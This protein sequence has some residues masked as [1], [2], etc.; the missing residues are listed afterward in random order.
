[1]NRQLFSILVGAIALTTA[2]CTITVKPNAS[3]G[4]A[5]ANPSQFSSEPV[6]I[7]SDASA[8][9]RQI[10]LRESSAEEVLDRLVE[11]CEPETEISYHSQT[12]V[13]LDGSVSAQAEGTLL[14]TLPIDPDSGYCLG[15]R[16][17][18][19]RQVTLEDRN[20]TYAI[21]QEDY[22]H[23]YTI[24]E[25]RS[26]SADSRYLISETTVGYDGGD[27]SLLIGFVDVERGEII[28]D[29][30]FCEVSE[31]CYQEFLG[32]SGPSEVV[33]ACSGLD[34]PQLIEAINLDT[35]EVRKFSGSIDDLA[36][37]GTVESG[38]KVVE[39]L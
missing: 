31:G 32:F 39:R 6:E 17:T 22:D 11:S 20:G 7:E 8:A 18:Y 27:G 4:A 37:Y 10:A 19:N 30:T 5:D 36:Q 23:G 13:S 9:D 25:P 14:G 3:P 16:E 29:I 26:F 12:L 28:S 35:G 21:T 38:F 33:V 1:M 15:E 24:Y 34:Y 2:A